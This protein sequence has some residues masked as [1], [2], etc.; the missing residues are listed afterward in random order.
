ML[1]IFKSTE[2]GDCTLFITHQ[3]CHCK[4]CKEERRCSP[5]GHSQP[6]A[7]FRSNPENANMERYQCSETVT[8]L[9]N[10]EA[11]TPSRMP[12]AVSDDPSGE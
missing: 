5:A 1:R 12:S 9:R 2:E 3:D 10:R 4:P 8:M 6:M 7:A 11:R